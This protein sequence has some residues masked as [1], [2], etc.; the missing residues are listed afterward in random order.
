MAIEAG[1]IGGKAYWTTGD[2]VEKIKNIT[3]MAKEIWSDPVRRSEQSKRIT[4]LCRLGMC[5]SKKYS[6]KMVDGSY[7]YLD[8]SWELA[9][10]E[11]LDDLETVLSWGRNEFNIARVNYFRYI[12]ITLHSGT[13]LYTG[14][15]TR[16]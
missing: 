12:I 4:E 3:K 1:A 15:E 14:R 10:A 13:Q 6:Y 9:V 16:L 7:V 11:L 8:S 2:V 5:L